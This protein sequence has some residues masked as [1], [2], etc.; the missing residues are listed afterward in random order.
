MMS[1]VIHLPDAGLSARFMNDSVNVRIREIVSGLRAGFESTRT[2]PVAWRREQLAAIGAMVTEHEADWI[3]ALAADLGRCAFEAWVAEIGYLAREVEFASRRIGRWMRPRRVHTPL[4][5]QPGASYVVPEPRGV[6]LIIGAWNY[7]LQ[8]TIAPLIAAVAAG[9]AA[10]VKPSE[11]APVTA[12]KL[13]E[14]VPRYLDPQSCAVVTGAVPETTALLEQRFDHVLYTGGAR[15]ARIVMAAAARHLT[16]V[17]LELGGKSPCYVDRNVDLDVAASRIA[18]GKFMNAGQTCI[19][20]DYVLAH[21]SVAG[22]IAGRLAARIREFYGEDPA[23][24][25]DYARIVNAP[26]FDR[27]LKLLAGQAI[28]HGGRYDRA[29]RYL[30]PTLVSDPALD[31]ELMQEEIF[32]PLL[33]ILAVDDVEAAIAFVRSRPKPLALYVF[34]SDREVEER[35]SGAVSAGSVCVNDT[36]MFM[37]APELPFGGVGASGMGRYSGW[38]GFETLSHMK[39][40]MRRSLHFDV[41]LRYPPY[42]SR[43]LRMLKKLM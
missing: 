36:M 12:A 29:S 34:S 18:W 22:E 30:E 24:S 42:S 10:V 37:A 14:L 19:A 4:V 16:P 2:Y 7:P 28:V 41:A 20:P 38:Y 8:L 9:N 3:E 13:A 35:V 33:P 32:G 40:V 17:T 26:H 23:H 1:Q 27:L 43:K 21:R 11:V 31:S 39:A 5:A 25:P 15:V 6:V